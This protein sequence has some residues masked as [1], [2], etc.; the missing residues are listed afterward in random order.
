MPGL[1][2]VLNKILHDR[3]LKVLWICLD[4]KY[5]RVTKQCCITN[6]LQD[7]EYSSGSEYGRVLNMLGLHKILGKNA[8]L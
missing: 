2:K 6:A 3:C 4:S 5:V 1:L 8:P 7:F